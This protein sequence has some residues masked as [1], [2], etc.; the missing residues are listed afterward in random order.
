MLEAIWLLERPRS[1]TL[2]SSC[3]RSQVDHALVEQD[4]TGPVSGHRPGVGV[5]VPVARVVGVVEAD[6][7]R[8][9]ILV[10]ARV[11]YSPS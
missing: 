5:S 11:Q 6:V 4:S 10:S 1:R 2:T 7:L 9:V 3:Q 8:W